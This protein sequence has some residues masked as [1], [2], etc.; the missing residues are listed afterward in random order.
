MLPTQFEIDGI[1]YVVDGRG[2]ICQDPPKVTQTYNVG[3][4]TSRYDSNPE[5]V[6]N[7]SFLRAGF[8][9]GAIGSI[10]KTLVDFGYGNGSF[11]DVMQEYGCDCYGYDISDYPIPAMVKRANKDRLYETQ[12]DIVTMFDSLEHCPNLS[13]I[14]QISSDYI[15]ITVPYCHAHKQ[16]IDWFR[17]WKHRRPGEH[18][19]HFNPQALSNLM[20]DYG[21]DRIG[22]SSIE[23]SIRKPVDYLENTFTAVFKNA[24]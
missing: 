3:Y 15:A 19:Y 20:R 8:I 12:W 7:M 22:L 9:I 21:Y 23:D 2:V 18:L 16:G 6:R 10:P 5:A 13:I 4:V 14:E 1:G 11:L 17:T 24:D